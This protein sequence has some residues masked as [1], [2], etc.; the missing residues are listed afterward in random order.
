MHQ[1]MKIARGGQR[2]MGVRAQG[3]AGGWGCAWARRR[4]PARPAARALSD[5]AFL[6]DRAL[7]LGARAAAGLKTGLGGGVFFTASPSRR[8]STPRR[9]SRRR[10]RSRGGHPLHRALPH[11]EASRTRDAPSPAALRST[12]R[13]LPNTFTYRRSDDFR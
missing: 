12:L 10:A 5:A 6:L 2:R 4:S 8:C 3:R 11:A 9:S 13:S 1:P 7:H